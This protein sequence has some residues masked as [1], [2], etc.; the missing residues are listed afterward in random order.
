MC[1]QVET[2]NIVIQN[3]ASGGSLSFAVLNQKRKIKTQVSV[4]MSG[5]L[6]FLLFPKTC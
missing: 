2:K 3:K 4:F 6:S 1:T 5:T